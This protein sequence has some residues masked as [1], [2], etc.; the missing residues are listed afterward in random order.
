MGLGD[1]LR[2]MTISRML[3][4]VLPRVIVGLLR[5]LTSSHDYPSR[6]QAIGLEVSDDAIG[7]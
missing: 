1:V 6:A 3:M 7:H 4:I 5:P 2:V